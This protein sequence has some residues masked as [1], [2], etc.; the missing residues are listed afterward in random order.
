MKNINSKIMTI[1][2]K[3]V[4][5]RE[6]YRGWAIVIMP[7]DIRLDNF[8]GFP[9]IHFKANGIHIPV[10]YDD[11]NIVFFIIQHHLRKYQKINK[12]ILIKKLIGD[13]YHD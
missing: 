11:A 9:H 13:V 2:D 3:N 5:F 10:L 12:L 4:Y 6:S 8:H 7:D 1:E